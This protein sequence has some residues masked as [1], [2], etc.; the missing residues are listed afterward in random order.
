MK[1]NKQFKRS[2]IIK[3]LESLGHTSILLTYHKS[4]GWWLDSDKFDGWLG[5]NSHQVITNI[6]LGII[7]EYK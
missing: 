4:E 7:K 3:L 1:K 6:K 5:S 2:C